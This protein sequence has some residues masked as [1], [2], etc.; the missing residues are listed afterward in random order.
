MPIEKYPTILVLLQTSYSNVPWF[1]MFLRL[2]LVP[3]NIE[4]KN[5]GYCYCCID[6]HD[7][8][9]WRPLNILL[10][11]ICLEAF[12]EFI[13]FNRASWSIAKFCHSSRQHCRL[14]R[15]AEMRFEMSET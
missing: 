11:A 5:V 1:N 6:F 12:L 13:F 10:N 15:A 9:S 2:H 14:G 8:I 7:S 4:N 3:F